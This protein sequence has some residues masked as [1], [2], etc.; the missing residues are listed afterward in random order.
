MAT[1]TLINSS[2]NMTAGLPLQST[3]TLSPVAAG[4]YRMTSGNYVQDIYGTGLTANASGITGGTITRLDY[5]N[6]AGSVYSI[7]GLTHSAVTIFG[8]GA[9]SVGLMDFLLNG[10]DSIT[11]SLGSETL[12]GGMGADTMVGGSGNDTYIVD[13]V[14]DV[15]T[16]NVGAG[17]D[18][19]QSSI[20]YSLIDTD[21]AGVNGGN[22]ENLALTG[23][24][25]I[26]ATGNS[27]NNSLSGNSGNNFLDGGTGTD[28][29]SGGAGNDIYKVD[30]AGDVVTEAS[31][32]GFDSVWTT[33][34]TYT[35]AANIEELNYVGVN[36]AAFT[37]TGNSLNNVLQGWGGNDTLDGGSGSDTMVGF[38]GN[39]TY[40]VDNADDTVTE[41][42]A[43]GTDSVLSSVTH[44]LSAN[45]ENLTLTGV[46]NSN[47]TGNNLNNNL[48][49]NSGNN[50]L[51]GGAGA[52][53]MVG[54]G[55][56]DTYVVNDAGDVVDE[57][58]D[59]GT[60][61]VLSSINYTLNDLASDV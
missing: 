46:A 20:T 8:F 10:N 47:A 24:G 38:A 15:V 19:I 56:N 40:I 6:S 13:D 34:A 48:T 45:V 32:E 9:D 16:E 39:D 43:E 31:G 51:D 27:G 55:G 60:D 7:T 35:L 57:S 23:T 12:V 52:D 36:T 4:H 22:V 42:A 21:G 44:T 30:D 28:V 61:T 1:V 41:N 59:D 5:S 54:N 18:T 49:G 33:L 29:M 14:S 53:A 17:T 2:L 25:N 3:G 26:N 11:G 58:F 50:I 37:G